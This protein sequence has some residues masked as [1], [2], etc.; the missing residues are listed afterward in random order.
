[1]TIPFPTAQTPSSS[2]APASATLLTTLTRFRT[3]QQTR[4][5]LAH[6]LDD[7]LSSYLSASASLPPPPP[8][9]EGQSTCAHEASLPPSQAELGEVL[10]IGF[11]GL[12]EV[13]GEMLELAEKLEVEWHRADLGAVV[14]KVEA[15]EGDRLKATLERDQLRRLA[16]LEDGADFTAQ[17]A[18]LEAKLVQLLEF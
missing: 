10:R 18:E 12:M 4:H 15:L 3:L 2:S 5:A 7:A 6:E 17:V 16:V 8:A 9:A 11:E 13:R 1:M 14:G